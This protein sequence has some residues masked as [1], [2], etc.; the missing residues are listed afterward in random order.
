MSYVM[1]GVSDLTKS[2]SFYRDVLGL[3]VTGQVEGEFVFFETGGSVQL[4]LRKLASPRSVNPGATEFVFE[5]QDINETYEELKQK[6]ISFTQEP[7]AVTE[8]EST[9][10]YATD[11]RDPDGHILS[12]TEWQA[13][14]KENTL[15]N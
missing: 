1:L 5:V 12:I 11:C 8:N 4:A 14:K 6:G 10:L 2:V 7:R 3:K 13:K 9:E 15:S